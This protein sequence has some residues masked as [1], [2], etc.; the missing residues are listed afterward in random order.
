MTPEDRVKAIAELG[1]T[2]RQARF[3]VTVM[4]HSGVCLLRQ[5]SAFAGIV[6]GQKTRKFFDK[7]VR[8]GYAS[9]YRC[10]HNRGQVY[11][12]DRKPLYRA[13][14]EAESR[15]RRPMSAAA[16]L[17]NLTVLDAL[18][19]TPGGSWLTRDYHGGRTRERVVI[20][21][22]ANGRRR[23]VYVVTS[24]WPLDIHRALQA[25][26]LRSL[27]QP[28]WTVRVVIPRQFETARTL[29]EDAVRQEFTSPAPLFTKDIA[30]YFQHRRA[31]G[32][33]E[34]ATNDAERHDEARFAFGAPRYQALYQRWLKHGDAVLEVISSSATADALRSGAGR[35]EYHVLPFSYRHLS[36]ILDA[37]SVPEMGAEDG[38][39]GGTAPRPPLTYLRDVG[40]GPIERP[41]RASARRIQRAVSRALAATRRAERRKRGGVLCRPRTPASET[42]DGA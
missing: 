29:V 2:E 13:I 20:G 31:R 37:P 11:H 32:R 1:F 14:G 39:D 5:Y 38:D 42:A 8:C 28:E 22:D 17:E 41:G 35:V 7:L 19:A 33:G 25:C 6:H 24:A 30:S 27:T 15:F 34:V 36:P 4:L 23:V 10:R 21:A 12:V 40:R 16:V 26:L 9:A 18:V 3:L